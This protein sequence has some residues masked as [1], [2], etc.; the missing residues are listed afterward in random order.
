MTIECIKYTPMNKG[1]LLGFA[2]IYV[3]KMGIEIFGCG[4]YEKSGRRWCSFPARE[5]TDKEGKKKYMPYIRFRNKDHKELF[6]TE[7]LKTVAPHIHT[8]SQEELAF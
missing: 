4:I 5:Y 1:Y 3:P 2:D 8:E 6:S 7:V